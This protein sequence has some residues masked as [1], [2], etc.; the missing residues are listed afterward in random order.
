MD[1]LPSTASR[2]V[3]AMEQSLEEL[4]KV[5]ASSEEKASPNLCP[6]GDNSLFIPFHRLF[7]G[8]LLE[9]TAGDL[10]RPP[11]G[12]QSSPWW[13]R[14]EPH[15]TRC[16]NQRSGMWNKRP[17]PHILLEG[18]MLYS[19]NECLLS[20]CSGCATLSKLLSLSFLSCRMGL[21]NCSELKDLLWKLNELSMFNGS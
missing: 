15:C 14:Q 10:S 4:R 1:W 7:W 2:T 17:T 6:S 13:N 9:V 3:L 19:H 8:F 11:D 5:T 16:K 21:N 12:F 18:R 20:T